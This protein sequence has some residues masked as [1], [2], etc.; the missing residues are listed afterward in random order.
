MTR[1][2][3]SRK[4]TRATPRTHGARPPQ[5]TSTTA[6]QMLD[7]YYA[8]STDETPERKGPDPTTAAAAEAP[9]PEDSMEKLLDRLA[10]EVVP[11]TYVFQPPLDIDS[12][13]EALT[14]RITG[15]RQA[16]PARRTSTDAFVHDQ[17]VPGLVPGCGP[18]AV[19]AK[20][21]DAHPG[22]WVLNAQL[23]RRVDDRTHAERA[24]LLIP[25]RIALS[26]ASWS[27]R[28]W[29]VSNGVD[30]PV[31]SSRSPFVR[32]PAVQLGSWA[33]IRTASAT[34]CARC[35]SRSSSATD[36]KALVA[37][38]IWARPCVGDHGSGPRS[39]AAS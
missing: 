39:G 14:L 30:G 17:I 7:A 29:R 5:T 31:N 13:P 1:K 37:A 6:R 20:I 32:S 2:Q 26:Q 28:R 33:A 21:P 25:T 4:P 16:V 15:R 9:E 35:S 34:Q 12:D 27:W 3:G 8:G 19:T 38:E 24:P 11:A 36:S 18:V 23:L 10:P 22:E